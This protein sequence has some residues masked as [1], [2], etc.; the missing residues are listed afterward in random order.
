MKAALIIYLFFISIDIFATEEP[1]PYKNINTN[2]DIEKWANGN[3]DAS[4]RVMEGETR[5]FYLKVLV[6]NGLVF[7]GSRYISDRSLTEA[8]K[9]ANRMLSKREDI[10]ANLIKNKADIVII[11]PDENYC[12]L[13]ETEV[14]KSQRTF[15]GRSFCDICGAGGNS[16]RPIT[17]VCEDNLLRT[18]K[19]PYHGTEDILTHELAHTI[20]GLGMTNEMK[21]Q[22][23]SL[24]LSAKEKGI[25][26][27]NL[28]GQA[29]YM[30][31]NDEEF[32]GCLTAAWF[33][34]HNPRSPAFS[35]DLVDRNSIKEKLPEMY[36]FMKSIY[37]EN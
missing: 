9:T 36:E 34:V 17:V 14:L 32:F 6:S 15:D 10:R 3:I 8:A 31:A 12:S 1:C 26:T 29:T 4:L 7:K 21:E 22:L 35:P 33:G 25:F 28:F 27:K 13:P 30:M 24:Y 37:P 18:H 2:L 16:G 20:H 5:P 11:A 19:D 23:N